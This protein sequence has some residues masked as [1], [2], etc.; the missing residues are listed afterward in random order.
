MR[1][2]LIMVALAI[3]LLFAVACAS[4]TTAPAPAPAPAP[5]TAAAPAAVQLPTK[6]ATTVPTSGGVP[7]A[8]NIPPMPTPTK[9]KTPQERSKETVKIVSLG[10]NEKIPMTGDWKDIA[11]SKATPYAIATNMVG[12]TTTIFQFNAGVHVSYQ[13]SGVSIDLSGDCTGSTGCHF[14]GVKDT[15]GSMDMRWKATFTIYDNAGKGV[16]RE[17]YIGRFGGTNGTWKVFLPK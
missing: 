8:S 15:S 7:V 12:L 16:D 9:T 6:A 11:F 13:E 5:V 17:F 4:Q 14:G 1:N 3:V 2:K 10:Q